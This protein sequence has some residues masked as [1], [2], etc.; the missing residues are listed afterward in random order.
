MKVCGMKSDE[1]SGGIRTSATQFTSDAAATA[2]SSPDVPT[3]PR[4]AARTA[5]STT[6]ETIMNLSLLEMGVGKKGK[7]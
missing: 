1:V 7:K 6:F 4:H 5:A 3:A 2:A